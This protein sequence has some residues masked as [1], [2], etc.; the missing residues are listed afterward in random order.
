MPD[1]ATDFD[2]LFAV[3]SV[4]YERMV[5]LYGLGVVSKMEVRRFLGLEKVGDDGS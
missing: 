5:Q 3:P 4:R 1:D 2:Q